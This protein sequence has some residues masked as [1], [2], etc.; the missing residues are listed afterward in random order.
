MVE[1]RPLIPQSRMDGGLSTEPHPVMLSS[2]QSPDQENTIAVHRALQRRPG[3][4]PLNMTPTMGSGLKSE[5]DTWTGAAVNNDDQEVPRRTWRGS[6]IIPYHPAYHWDKNADLNDISELRVRFVYQVGHKETQNFNA[7]YE[8]A[9]SSYY[10]RFLVGSGKCKAYED[11]EVVL[12]ETIWLTNDIYMPDWVVYL[13]DGDDPMESGGA[14]SGAS[15]LAFAINVNGV[16]YSINLDTPVEEGEEI[17]ILADAFRNTAGGQI[18]YALRAVWSDGRVD[19]VSGIVDG[20]DSLVDSH[21]T[22]QI[23]GPYFPEYY[24]SHLPANANADA[25]GDNYDWERMRMIPGEGVIEDLVMSRTRDDGILHSPFIWPTKTR[26]HEAQL[27]DRQ[28]TVLGHWPGWGWQDRQFV[29]KT[30]QENHGYIVPGAPCL[31]EEDGKLPGILCDRVSEWVVKDFDPD[32]ETPDDDQWQEG[33]MLRQFALVDRS[34][35]DDVHALEDESSNPIYISLSIGATVTFHESPNHIG[36]A[37]FTPVVCVYKQRSDHIPNPVEISG[38]PGVP[39]NERICEIEA[40]YGANNQFRARVFNT[41]GPGVHL[42]LQGPTPP[43]NRP[44]TVMLSFHIV[45]T[46]THYNTDAYLYV[47]GVL[48]DHD[49]D[50]WAN[51]EVVFWGPIAEVLAGRFHGEVHDI[52]MGIHTDD[53]SGGIPGTV[54]QVPVPDVPL[55]LMRHTVQATGGGWTPAADDLVD[56]KSDFLHDGRRPGLVPTAGNVK[57]LAI[58]LLGLTTETEDNGRDWVTGWRNRAQ[59]GVW[60]WTVD[61]YAPMDRVNRTNTVYDRARMEVSFHFI[62]AWWRAWPNR[63][64]DIRARRP[65]TPGRCWQHDF[66][67]S[68]A[69]QDSFFGSKANTG[70][71]DTM[72]TFGDM[73]WVGTWSPYARYSNLAPA[74]CS[75]VFACP[76]SQYLGPQNR[77]TSPMDLGL[78]WGEGCRYPT[79]EDGAVG[80]VHQWQDDVGREIFLGGGRNLYLYSPPLG[81]DV[82]RLRVDGRSYWE[83]QTVTNGLSLQ[84][85][86]GVHNVVT[87]AFYYRRKSTRIVSRCIAAAHGDDGTDAWVIYEENGVLVISEGAPLYTTHTC[88]LVNLPNIVDDLFSDRRMHWVVIE[89]VGGSQAT[90]CSVWWDGIPLTVSGPLGATPVQ[91][92]DYKLRVGGGA[93]RCRE[94]AHHAMVDSAADADC[95]IKDVMITSRLVNGSGPDISILP[96]KSIEDLDDT[97]ALFKVPF[98]D[99]HGM[100]AINLLASDNP[101]IWF[102]RD[103]KL[104]HENLPFLGLV[105]KVPETI[106]VEQDAALVVGTGLPRRWRRILAD[107]TEEAWKVDYL[108]LPDPWEQPLLEDPAAA[109]DYYD[110]GHL[111]NELTYSAGITFYDEERDIRTA[112]VVSSNTVSPTDGLLRLRDLPGLPYGDAT[113]LEVWLGSGTSGVYRLAKRA[114]GVDHDEIEVAD[115]RYDEIVYNGDLVG[116]PPISEH[117]AILQERLYLGNLPYISSQAVMASAPGLPWSFPAANVIQFGDSQDGEVTALQTG[118]GRILVAQEGLCSWFTPGANLAY[119]EL[120][121]IVRSIGFNSRWGPVT[122]SGPLFGMTNRGPAILDGVKFQFIG[123][124]VRQEFVDSDRWWTVYDGD[125][126]A[127]WFISE[128]DGPWC[129]SMM[130]TVGAEKETWSKCKFPAIS[131]VSEIIQ[132]QRRSLVVGTRLGRMATLDGSADLFHADWLGQTDDL[133]FA[134]F[135]AIG[136][137]ELDTE[138]DSQPQ[139]LRGQPLCG[140]DGEAL[141]YGP[142]LNLW[143]GTTD[144]TE[145]VVST[146]TDYLTT[147]GADIGALSAWWTCP[148]LHFGFPSERKEV[149]QMWFCFA[150]LGETLNVYFDSA[151]QAAVTRYLEAA[152]PD[153]PVGSAT[154]D[155]TRGFMANPIQLHKIK[156]ANGVYFRFKI[157]TRSNRAPWQTFYYIIEGERAGARASI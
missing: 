126:R 35:T 119:S 50:S 93:P 135:S 19:T 101:M 150:A 90:E 128:P 34:T 4:N 148:W 49:T 65:R 23:F 16:I 118:M 103:L 44:V 98:D 28:E 21:R 73:H 7:Y 9:W 154:V 139:F 76:Y 115:I 3:L 26:I 153:A 144:I 108:G 123:Q 11:D 10:R 132:N 68:V 2:D 56:L 75:P 5:A 53:M 113:H 112:M 80:F 145:L 72:N 70:L 130:L 124:D 40:W 142:Y 155:L 79:D 31:L 39:A 152:F 60:D 89:L 41:G 138:W 17:D 71:T 69:N 136:R 88:H 102:G 27:R 1:K 25:Q 96:P 105:D 47:N 64:G 131:C 22:I 37:E 134:A 6:G 12:E 114:R 30:E 61:T 33:S 51:A 125:L 32:T 121:E 94:A 110:A 15:Y 57:G 116:E 157:A 149:A 55:S 133:E 104:L 85:S 43:L 151:I 78:K 100:T 92:A 120:R 141:I 122:W 95:E 13:I 36:G 66:H 111:E 38:D 147:E 156:G 20:E 77:K 42:E 18:G 109:G 29:D 52:R 83:A 146:T 48:V 8:G 129:Q 91:N 143:A 63:M 86:E 24:W 140:P 87:I 97:N 107:Q 117:V 137:A 46:A 45:K 81:E 58:K 67:V 54:T 14:A 106:Q 62:Y 99:G 59:V 127:W 84:P 74:P 82:T